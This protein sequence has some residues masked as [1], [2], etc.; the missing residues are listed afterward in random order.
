MGKA[1][2]QKGRKLRASGAIRF[3]AQARKLGEVRQGARLVELIGKRELE[4]RPNQRCLFILFFGGLRHQI[5]DVL[6]E[7]R[8]GDQS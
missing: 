6:H 3:F 1:A 4:G 5:S 2:L 7:V 8:D